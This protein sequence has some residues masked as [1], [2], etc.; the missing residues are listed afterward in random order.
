MWQVHGQAKLQTRLDSGSSFNHYALLPLAQVA[1]PCSPCPLDVL[2]PLHY[3]SLA[4][5]LR[6][7]AHR[8]RF[9]PALLSIPRESAICQVPFLPSLSLSSVGSRP[10]E[11][12]LGYSMMASA[13]QSKALELQEEPPQMYRKEQGQSGW[14]EDN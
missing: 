3:I 9:S 11:G 13:G 12:W 6:A 1:T 10:T 7:Q 2:E 8:Y 4:M 5:V 14:D